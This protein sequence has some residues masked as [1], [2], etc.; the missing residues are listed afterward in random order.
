MNYFK[1]LL[2]VLSLAFWGCS[3]THTHTE[4]E[5]HSHESAEVAHSHA[6]EGGHSHEGIEL[7]KVQY[8]AYNA[9]FELFA[10]AEIGRAHV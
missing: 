7:E 2:I 9:D 5:A 8:T 6:E 4:E 10:E 3:Q 1:Y